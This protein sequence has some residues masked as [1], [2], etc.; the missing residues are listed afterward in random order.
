MIAESKLTTFIANQSSYQRTLTVLSRIHDGLCKDGSIKRDSLKVMLLCG[1][2]LLESFS[3]PG[4]WIRDQVKSICRDFGVIC[5]RREGTNI[6]QIIS[7]D[8][9]L[10]ENKINVISVDEI[11]PNRISSTNVRECISRGLSVKYLIP[12]EVIDYIRDQKLY[13][14]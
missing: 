11:I 2:D 9:I 8:E 6:E 5:I 10:Q 12:D 14:E 13:L 1:S 7:N 4:A 3:I